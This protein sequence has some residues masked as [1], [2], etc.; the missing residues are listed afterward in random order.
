M[1]KVS[2]ITTIA[3]GLVILLLAGAVAAIPARND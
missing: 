1:K 2:L 3:V